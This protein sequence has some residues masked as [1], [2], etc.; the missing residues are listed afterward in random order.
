MCKAGQQRVQRSLSSGPSAHCSVPIKRSAPVIVFEA[1][2]LA[3]PSRNA[4]TIVM[5]G[6][7]RCRNGG[8]LAR[9]PAGHTRALV[10]VILNLIN[11]TADVLSRDPIL[12]PESSMRS[13][14]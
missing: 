6:P 12:F 2:F 3:S 1:G 7:L 11:S 10:A 13:S 14:W 4:D 8:T 5:Y 9:L